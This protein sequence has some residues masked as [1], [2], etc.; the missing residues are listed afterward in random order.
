MIKK[1]KEALGE[2]CRENEPMSK[3]TTLRIGGPADLFF[4]AKSTKEFIN[5]IKLARSFGVPVTILGDGS[6]VLISDSG[7]RGLVLVNKSDKIEVLEKVSRKKKSRKVTARWESDSKIGTFKYEFKDLDYDES[8]YP[9]VRVKMDSGVNLPSALDYL[10]ESGITGLQWYAGIPGTIGG[11]IFNNIHGG[12]HFISEVIESV[13]VLNKKGKILTLTIDELGVGYDKSR[14]QKSGEIILDGVFK[15]YLGDVEKAKY[16]KKEWGK[17]KSIQPRNSPGCAFHNLTQR[18]KTKLDLPTTSVGFV[19]EHMLGLSGFKIGGAAIS[20]KH[21][22]FIV[23]EGN[24][25]AKD[26]LAVMREI[27]QRARKKLGV[28][29]VSEI[30][31]LGFKEEEIKEFIK[32]ELVRLRKKRNKE[33]RTVY[34]DSKKMFSG[35]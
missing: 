20:K 32:P 33:I 14:F 2:A 25:T 34:K 7:I 13:R 5:V 22:N 3:Y 8:K 21:H 35:E 19:I 10:L 11:G 29:L 9:E 15:L 28:T 24:A 27:F 23:N 12:T 6:N 18:Q 16:V 1:L 31:L 30:F 17:R 26:Y 4:S